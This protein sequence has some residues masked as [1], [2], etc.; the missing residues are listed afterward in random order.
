MGSVPK[1]IIIVFVIFLSL[2][3]DAILLY[4]L[5]MH[6]CWILVVVYLIQTLGGTIGFRIRPG[7]AR[8]GCD[9]GLIG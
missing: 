3:A 8:A 4:C 2:E 9:G 1:W 5:Y 7:Q 6:V